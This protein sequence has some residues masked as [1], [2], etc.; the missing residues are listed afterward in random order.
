MKTPTPVLEPQI[1]S[2]QPLESL[3]LSARDARHSA[4]DELNPDQLTDRATTM[5][6]QLRALLAESGRGESVLND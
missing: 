6:P 3:S 2:P 1:T 5:T 4:A